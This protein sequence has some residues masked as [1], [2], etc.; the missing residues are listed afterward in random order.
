MA[1]NESEREAIA[2]ANAHTT[3]AGLPSYTDLH[4]A[5]TSIP[6]SALPTARLRTFWKG[7]RHAGD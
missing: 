1:L 4:K 5:L 7:I 6:G 2:K 3:S